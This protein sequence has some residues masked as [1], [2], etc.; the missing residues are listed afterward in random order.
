MRILNRK[1]MRKTKKSYIK[2]NAPENMLN[3]IF[4]NI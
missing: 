4:Y 1:H 2:N 3:H